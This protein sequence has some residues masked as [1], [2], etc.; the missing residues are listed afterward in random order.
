[1]KAGQKGFIT[2][3]HLSQVEFEFRK[4]KKKKEAEEGSIRQYTVHLPNEEMIAS[5]R[6]CRTMTK[7]LWNTGEER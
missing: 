2:N 5:K 3:K 4:K 6:F 1:M 7:D